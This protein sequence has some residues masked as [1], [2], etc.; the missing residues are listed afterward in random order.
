[1]SALPVVSTVNEVEKVPRVEID[2]PN[3]LRVVER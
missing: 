3:R 1:V 2:D